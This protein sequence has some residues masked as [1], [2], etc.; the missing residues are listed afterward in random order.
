MPFQFHRLCDVLTLTLT[1]TARRSMHPRSTS[2]GLSI[3][4]VF[5]AI[6]YIQ[7]IV[8]FPYTRTLHTPP[9]CSWL[10]QWSQVRRMRILLWGLRLRRRKIG[11]ASAARAPRWRRHRRRSARCACPIW[12]DRRGA[13]NPSR[14]RRRITSGMRSANLRA[15]GKRCVSGSAGC[16]HGFHAECIGRWLPL[17]AQ[18]P[19][20]RLP[21]PPEV[22]D[23]GQ[24]ATLPADEAPAW[25]RPARM[26]CGFGDGRVVWTRSPSAQEL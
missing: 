8:H 2:S 13:A 5:F 12:P 1:L 9:R 3:I 10:P 26:A 20:C 11:C 14:R 19:L 15:L 25:S 16:G 22:A 18:C 6:A 17:R 23:D 21:V 4:F 24:P 7:Y